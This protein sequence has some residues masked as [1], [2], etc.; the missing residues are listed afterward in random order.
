MDRILV[1]DEIEESRAAE[2]RREQET[3]GARSGPESALKP[4]DEPRGSRGVTQARIPTVDQSAYR[5][6]FACTS[7]PPNT[8]T[9]EHEA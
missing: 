8:P 5:A 9:D 4:A 3:G 2:E 1:P 6:V 7:C